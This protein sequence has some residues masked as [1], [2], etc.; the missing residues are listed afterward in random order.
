MPEAPGYT[1]YRPSVTRAEPFCLQLR[2]LDGCSG[3]GG[4][5]LRGEL[6]ARQW[7]EAAGA[8]ALALLPNI[9]PQALTKKLVQVATVVALLWR[10]SSLT[11]GAVLR[12]QAPHDGTVAAEA[13]LGRVATVWLSCRAALLCCGFSASCTLQPSSVVQGE[14]AQPVFSAAAAAAAR[15]WVEYSNQLAAF[16]LRTA[17]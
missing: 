13:S 9:D 17:R 3:V 14:A 12:A 5:Q 11:N 7:C 4:L 15:P 6:L 10:T 2:V 16:I 1:K 8:A